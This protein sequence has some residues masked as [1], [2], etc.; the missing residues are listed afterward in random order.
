M[1]RARAWRAAAGVTTAAVISMAAP[2]SVHADNPLS[3][4]VTPQV[5]YAPA[6]VQALVR[7]APHPDNRILRVTL[8]SASYYRSSDVPLE[9]AQAPAAHWLRWRSVPAGTY[10][11]TLELRRSTGDHRFLVGGRIRVLGERE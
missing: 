1:K 2:A 3:A 6:K 10:V 11:V 5:A 9:G 7:V 8:E 4:S